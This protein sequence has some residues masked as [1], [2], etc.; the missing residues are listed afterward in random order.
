MRDLVTWFAAALVVAS[1]ALAVWCTRLGTTTPSPD[2]PVF[3]TTEVALPTSPIRHQ[4]PAGASGD[5]GCDFG[6]VLVIAATEDPAFSS[7][8]VRLANGTTTTVGQGE[9]VRGYTVEAIHWDRVRFRRGTSTCELYIGEPPATAPAEGAAPAP[10][11]R[12]LPG[13]LAR[14][15]ERR[16]PGEIAVERSIVDRIIEESATLLRG[17]RARRT[18]DGLR[19]SRVRGVLASLG[20]KAG[21]VLHEVNGFDLHDP[22]QMVQAYAKLQTAQHLTLTFSRGDRRS[23]LDVSVL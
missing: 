20:F 11:D 9:S 18:T 1:V 16:G 8:A 15:I 17:S 3:A 5:A 19:L 12:R 6:E 13:W 7:T 22:N 2:A 21:D 14:G 4:A 10:T 23:E